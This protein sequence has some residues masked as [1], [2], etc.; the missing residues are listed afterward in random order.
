MCFQR[1]GF[2][3]LRFAGESDVVMGQAAWGGRRGRATSVVTDACK[4]LQ[5]GGRYSDPTAVADRSKCAPER[6]E[7]DALPSSKAR[8]VRECVLSN[9]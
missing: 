6:T 7:V 1:D 2:S 5:V 8:M 4:R 3:S 9:K